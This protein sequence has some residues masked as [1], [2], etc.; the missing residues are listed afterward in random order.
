MNSGPRVLLT[1]AS[2]FV[3]RQVAARL[4]ES[5]ELHCVSRR[6]GVVVSG[7]AIWH[8]ANLLDPAACAG[9]I[10]SVGPSHLVHLAWNA[11]HGRFWTAPDNT[12]W[13]DAG[14]AL[15]RAFGEAGGKR[16]VISGTGAEYAASAPSPLDESN[17]SPEPVTLYGQMKNEFRLEA[18]R[19]AGEYG[20]SHAWARI[21]NVYGEGEDRRR[22]V[23]SII[24]ALM[25]GERA[26]CSS[27]RQLR[28]FVDVR[29][30]G[31]ALAALALSELHGDINLGSGYQATI[32][33]VAET[34]GRLM[35]RPGLVV[36]GALP[37]RPGEPEVQ[38]PG[39][40]RMRGELG[41]TPRIG[42]EQGL[43]DAIGWWAAQ[44]GD[45]D[46]NN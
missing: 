12:L 46:R 40:A 8:A 17:P 30:L 39:L 18:R 29:D 23:P 27:G 22:L 43:Q 11:A 15:V 2:G 4:P 13:R 21:F 25:R 35:G 44:S 45:T 5:I 7:G 38:V 20:V 9:L 3:G 28:D 24:R 19:I 6:P 34:I 33:Q 32:A 42:L 31:G 10:A 16:L 36:L 1:G 37:D 26:E 14:I 41:F